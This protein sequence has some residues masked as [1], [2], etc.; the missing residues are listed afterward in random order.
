[1]RRLFVVAALVTL[2]FSA[3]QPQPRNGVEAPSTTRALSLE[4]TAPLDGRET[5]WGFVTVTGIVSSPE[6]QV[7]VSGI[8]VDV[9]QDGSFES[10]YILLDEGKNKLTAV[11]TLEGKTVSKTVTVTYTLKLHVS[12]SLNLERGKDW[13]TESPTKIGGRVSDP[14]AEVIV[15]GKKAEV[16]KDGSISAMLN[17]TDGKNQIIATARL[18]DQ[19]DTD[20][21]EAIYVPPVPLKLN[22]ASPTDGGEIGLDLLR[23]TG[24]VS[25]PEALITVNNI[26]ALVTAAGAFYAYV[27]LESG[28]NRIDTVVT[29]GSENMTNTIRVTYNPVTSPVG[30]L[31]LELLS[32]RNKTE[33][34]VNVIPVTGVVGDPQS[35]VLVDGR[36]A[37]VSTSGTFQGYVVLDEGKNVIEVVAFKDALKTIKNIEVSFAPPLVVLL[38][39]SS[40]ARVVDYRKEPA[41]FTGMV[42]KPE[43]QVQFSRLLIVSEGFCIPEDVSQQGRCQA[44]GF[45]R[46]HH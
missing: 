6:A 7:N 19:I 43:A 42:N 11:A 20:T 31:A 17:L 36:E 39:H 28:E 35:M 40:S 38:S 46:V 3:C 44:E 41:T 16:G 24:T 2:I 32:P 33:Y 21:R 8:N 27:E 12:I 23:V 1:M 26:K 29:R 4:I 15:N 30:K 45:H 37:V 18:R 9:G 34:R 22:I 10:D 13:L 5:A 14:R 25:D